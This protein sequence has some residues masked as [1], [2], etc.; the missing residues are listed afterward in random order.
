MTVQ[1]QREDDPS[2]AKSLLDSTKAVTRGALN[3]IEGVKVSYCYILYY[4]SV[5][6]TNSLLSGSHI[7]H[8]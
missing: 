5:F 8:T 1:S 6:I 2:V 4:V 7:L 3:V